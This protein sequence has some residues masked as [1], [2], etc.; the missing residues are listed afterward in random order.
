MRMGSLVKQRRS[1]ESPS[2]KPFEQEA[3][4]GFCK[5]QNSDE[6]LEFSPSQVV[7]QPEIQKKKNVQLPTFGGFNTNQINPIESGDYTS[8]AKNNSK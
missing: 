2:K 3:I 7:N 4:N 6:D 8:R 1:P 5:R